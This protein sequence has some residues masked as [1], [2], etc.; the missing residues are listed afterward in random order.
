MKVRMSSGPTYDSKY[1]WDCSCQGGSSGIVLPSGSFDK[2][3]GG[4][5]LN[6]LI[7]G[8]SSKESYTTAFFEAFPN[9]PRTFIRGEGKT[10][11]E[12]EESCWQK[13][14]KILICNHEMERRNRT[15]GYGY[16][17][18][19]SYSST[20]FEPLT[21]CC[22][23]GETTAYSQDYRGKWYCKKHSRVKPKN[24]NPSRWEEMDNRVPRKR[25]KLLKKC[26]LNKFRNEQIFG[27]VKF[28]CKFSKKFTCNNK[29]FTILFKR[30]EVEFI[31]KYKNYGN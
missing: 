12:A 11:E 8:M 9:K 22:K 21:K 25:K 14:Q 23:C 19:C 10:I 18:H 6:G 4:D 16:C 1:D 27:T 7:E 13:Y 30:Q 5:P 24:P 17:K 3:F 29:Q 28:S 15:D 26:A 31:K 20:V 2:V